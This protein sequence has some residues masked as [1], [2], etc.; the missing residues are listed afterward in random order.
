MAGWIRRVAHIIN[1]STSPNGE[2][3][4]VDAVILDAR[5]TGKRKDALEEV[6]LL[7]HVSPESG[8]HFIIQHTEYIHPHDIHQLLQIGQKV[9]VLN[10]SFHPHKVQLVV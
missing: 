3:K 6:M 4:P 9:R 10:T 8:R 2:S 1:G 5:V 7:L